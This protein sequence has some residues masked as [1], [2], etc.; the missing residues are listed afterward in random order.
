MLYPFFAMFNLSFVP[1]GEIY[2]QGGKIFYSP[3]TLENYANVF[4]KIP[5]WKYF[6]NSLFLLL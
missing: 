5:I 4:S 6:I 2:N 3:L 1:N